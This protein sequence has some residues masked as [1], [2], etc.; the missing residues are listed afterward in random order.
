MKPSLNFDSFSD[1]GVEHRGLPFFS[2]NGRLES[3][4]LRRSLEVFQQM[5]LGGATPHTRYGLE[6]TYLGGHFLDCIRG[7]IDDAEELGLRVCL[8]DEDRWPSGYAGG[9]LTNDPAHRSKE[10]ILSPEPIPETEGG[11]ELFKPGPAHHLARYAVRLEDGK[12]AEYRRLGE[13]ASLPDGTAEWFASWRTCERIPSFNGY[14]YGDTL[15][16]ASMRRFCELVHDRFL[17]ACGGRFPTHVPYLFSDEPRHE[18]WHSLPTPDSRVRVTIPWT[19]D[20]P[21]TYRAAFSSELLDTLPEVFWDLPEGRASL[22]RWRLH[23][24]ISERF[25]AAWADIPADWCERHGIGLTVHLLAEERLSSQTFFSG[26][27]MRAFRRVQVPGVDQL[28]DWDDEINTYK[29]A[30]SVA[31]QYGR[32]EV[33]TELYGVTRWDFPFAGHKRQ[34]D[35][36]AA[37]GATLRVPHLNLMSLRGEAK[38]DYPASIGEH[39]PWWPQYSIIEDHFAR[40]HT[41]LTQGEADCPLAVVHPVESMWLAWGPG[42]A[43]ER[44]R[45]DERFAALSEWLTH[46]LIDFDFLA[47]SLLPE[48]ETS[49]ADGVLRVGEARYQTVLVPP[50]RTIRGSTLDLLEKHVAAGGEVHFL[51]TPSPLVDVANDERAKHLA[52]GR[53]VPFEEPAVLDAVEHLRRFD[54]RN[55]N[56]TRVNGVYSQVRQIGEN[57]VIFAANHTRGASAKRF[58]DLTASSPGRWQVSL[59]NTQTGEIQSLPSTV[60]GECTEWKTDLL[61]SGS[62]LVSLSPYRAGEDATPAA[63]TE[64]KP[65]LRFRG[66]V[67]TI[68]EEP[69]VLLLDRPEWRLPEEAAW[70][71]AGDLLNIDESLRARFGLQSRARKK[72]V[73]FQGKIQPWVL[74]DQP[75]VARVRLRFTLRC[76]ATIS[77]P[78]FA[79]ERPEGACLW[80]DDEA[81]PARPEGWWVDPD[82]RTLPLPGLAPGDHTLEVETSFGPRHELE[83]MY[84]LGEFDVDL[85]GETSRLGAPTSERHFGDITRQGLPFYSGNLTYQIPFDWPGG[86]ARLILPLYKAPLVTARLDGKDVG[87]LAF[88]PHHLHLGDPSPGSHNLELVLWNSREN[89]HGPLHNVDPDHVMEV[90]HSWRLAPEVYSPEYRVTEV[91]ILSGPLLEKPAGKVGEA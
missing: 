85:Q 2:L 65:A 7:V 63:E 28:C 77:A 27:V 34:G 86:P 35:L 59:L 58:S 78:R 89:S 71:P 88:E 76:D 67:K 8:Y 55:P 16:P 91:G 80:L 44:R 54:L 73:P 62:M 23:E 4:R 19:T 61:L 43:G 22:H 32:K 25:A 11:D 5:G 20:L 51:G 66:P 14:T 81:L 74:G 45:L 60:S 57:R 42:T 53:T 15:S 50:M 3:A 26:E 13:A 9:L 69:N 84:L 87:H 37:L 10:L 47:E 29:Q 46:G 38:R 72:G 82:L 24:H 52:Q 33:M 6:D 48:Q 64:W 18:P 40:L 17:E 30:V 31:R 75:P 90:P 79:M 56:G 36:C 12:L 41:I 39:S 68:R 83:W 21:Q 49:T 70:N 1:P